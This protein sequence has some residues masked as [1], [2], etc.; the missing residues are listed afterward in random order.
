MKVVVKEPQEF[1][2]VDECSLFEF[3]NQVLKEDDEH[4]LAKFLQI[5]DS[6]SVLSSEPTHIGQMAK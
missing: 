5:L 6:T 2:A 1:I 4:G 3:Q